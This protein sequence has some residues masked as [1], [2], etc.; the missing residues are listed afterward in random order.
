M[1]QCI[2]LEGRVREEGYLVIIVGSQKRVFSRFF[3][4]FWQYCLTT[5]F[6][7]KACLR[8]WAVFWRVVLICT[9]QVHNL[10]FLSMW[11]QILIFFHYFL[12]FVLLY[13]IKKGWIVG[14]FFF[15]TT[16]FF[17]RGSGLVFLV[18]VAFQ[19]HPK[20]FGIICSTII[21][22]KFM[23]NR[24]HE[25]HQMVKCIIIILLH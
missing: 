6:A 12:F 16:Y 22:Y 4:S 20:F 9:F 8:D 3:C 7:K 2:V 10:F 21:I 1:Y 23:Y 19:F 17:F 18:V 15:F 13:S 11:D 25:C 5:F 24:D 14:W